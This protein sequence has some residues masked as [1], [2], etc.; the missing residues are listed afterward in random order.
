MSLLRTVKWAV[1]DVVD[2]AAERVQTATGE[3]ARRQY[4]QSLKDMAETFKNKVTAA[5]D[6]LNQKI[7]AFNNRI[8]TLNQLR[9]NEISGKIDLLASFLRKFGNC[10]PCG[11]YA[12][13][14]EKLPPEFPQRELDAR[15]NYI[16]DNDWSKESVFLNTFMLSF[17]GMKRKTQKQNLALQEEIHDF[18]LYIRQTLDDFVLREQQTDQDIEICDMYLSNISTISHYIETTIIPEL[19]LVEAFFQATKI[20]DEILCDHVLNKPQ[21]SYQ[22]SSII[23]TPYE[24]HYRFVKNTFLFYVISCKVYDTP[25]L[26]NLLHSNTSQADKDRLN[27]E[28]DALNESAKA[29]QEEMAADRGGVKNA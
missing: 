21:F 16:K 13:E 7:N 3:K 22:L 25:V 26:T 5:I 14:A 12:D 28:K 27:Q 19:E 4:M 10:K 29:V 15:E 23:G 6:T 1:E 18:E 20:K 2:M 9:K 24:K 11:A 17:V 8:T